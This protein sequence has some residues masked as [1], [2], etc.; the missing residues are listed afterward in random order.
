M[1]A[2]GPVAGLN[3]P[4]AQLAQVP[5]PVAPALHTQSVR[6]LDAVLTV[7]DSPGHWVQDAEPAALAYCPSAQAVQVSVGVFGVP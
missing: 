7:V 3:V 6:A 2:A 1:H 4:T 5:L